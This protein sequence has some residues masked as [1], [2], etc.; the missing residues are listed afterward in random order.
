VAG[1]SLTADP[2]LR[3]GMTAWHVIPR[4]GVAGEDLVLVGLHDRVAC[5]PEARFAG[6]G[7]AASSLARLR[8]G[9]TG[10]AVAGKL[11]EW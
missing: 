3:F 10:Q 4:T 8:F 9:M 11:D 2:S 1:K 5:H 7:S 6:E